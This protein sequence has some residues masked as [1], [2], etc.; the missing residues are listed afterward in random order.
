MAVFRHCAGAFALALFALN[1]GQSFAAEEPSGT[2][3]AVIPAAAASGLNGKR[4]LEVTGPVFMGDRVQTGP[5][6]E[7][8][9]KFRDDT[10]L[11]VGPNSRM[12]IDAFVFNN[13][14][15]A[16]QVTMKAFR[17]TFRFI[18][19]NSRKQAYS[20]RTPTT[21]IGVRGTRFDFSVE[22]DGETRFAL[23]EG[24]ARLCDGRG[25]CK[26][27]RGT[28]AVAVVRPRE[29]ISDPLAGA[30]K[31][32]I[33]AASFPY[34]KSQA[35]L[36]PEFRAETSGCLLKRASLERQRDILLYQPVDVPTPNVAPP[37]GTTPTP[38][39]TPT[40]DP[41]PTPSATLGNPGN[42][43]A[44]GNAGETPNNKGGW[45]EPSGGPGTQGRSGAVASNG[46]GGGNNGN[47][48][49][50]GNN[51]N[52]GKALGHNK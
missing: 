36:R 16:R 10:R 30:E 34:V 41:T 44:V 26:E 22:R 13:D 48:G 37:P 7:A 28:C 42:N 18:T 17:G 40:P 52:N 25:R 38:T 15:T 35:R 46:N 23:L 14:N 11:V 4:V 21:T 51:G 9:I 49:N 24:E 33:L 3:V 47:K 1:T 12:V 45:G 32:Q 8:Q 6:G 39:P 27:I 43:K 50:N 2:T 5:A 31:A 19:G 20:I 29:G